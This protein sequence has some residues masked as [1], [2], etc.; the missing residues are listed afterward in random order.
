MSANALHFEGRASDRG[1]AHGGNDE[2]DQPLAAA[3]VVTREIAVRGARRGDKEIPLAG[4]EL[5]LRARDAA[6]E[7]FGA[8]TGVLRGGGLGAG[9]PAYRPTARPPTHQ[10]CPRHCDEFPPLHR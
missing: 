2:G 6:G 1:I 8:Q 3:G 9:R 5:G 4:L 10:R 7:D